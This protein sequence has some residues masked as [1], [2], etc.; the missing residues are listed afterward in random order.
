MTEAKLTTPDFALTAAVCQR[1]QKH[2]E[3]IPKALEEMNEAYTNDD[4]STVGG[5]LQYILA[6]ISRLDGYL[7]GVQEG[8]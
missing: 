6:I 4:M 8:L 5:R 1:V 3:T 2:L 7:E